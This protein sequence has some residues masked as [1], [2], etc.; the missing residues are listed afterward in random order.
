MIQ[1]TP[2]KQTVFEEASG[3]IPTSR[4]AGTIVTRTQQP[5][6]RGF[7]R[8]LVLFLEPHFMKEKNYV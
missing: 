6:R 8:W 1:I 5:D 2:H 4:R 7:D 3:S